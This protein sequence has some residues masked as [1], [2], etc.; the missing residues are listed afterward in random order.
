MVV[1]KFRTTV[2]FNCCFIVVVWSCFFVVTIVLFSLPNDIGVIKL[3]L[4]PF[5]TTTSANSYDFIN[6]IHSNKP[7]ASDPCVDNFWSNLY[8]LLQYLFALKIIS[9]I[10]IIFLVLVL[11]LV[12]LVPLILILEN[13]RE[14]RVDQ[15]GGMIPYSSVWI[16][17]QHYFWFWSSDFSCYIAPSFWTNFFLSSHQRS[18][19]DR[20][21]E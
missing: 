3:E 4:N 10:F 18:T 15:S 17:C 11:T 21:H 2:F 5:K 8:W 7:N 9:L 16:Q 20:G 19:L 12:F 13:H 6:W 1:W 14:K